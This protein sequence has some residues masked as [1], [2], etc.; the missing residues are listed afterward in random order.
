[1]VSE[2]GRVID[3]LISDDCKAVLL[4][5]VERAITCACPH[6]SG[7]AVAR[8][9]NPGP[10]EDATN[11]ATLVRLGHRHSAQLHREV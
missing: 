9:N 4:I 3:E 1:M 11:A 10:E 2:S 6:E 7:T 8:T 5:E